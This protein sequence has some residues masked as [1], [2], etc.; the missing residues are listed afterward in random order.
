[1]HYICLHN[2]SKLTPPL[3]QIED[4]D[5]KLLSCPTNRKP[6]DHTSQIKPTCPIISTGNCKYAVH[7]RNFSCSCIQG[8]FVYDIGMSGLRDNC[9]TY[10]HPLSEHSDA[11][12]LSEVNSNSLLMCHIL[13]YYIP[14][15]IYLMRSKREDIT[16]R[17][18]M[19]PR[20]K[21]Q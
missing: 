14:P 6:L 3:T 17:Y 12:S 11:Q 4:Q 5:H 2:S 7:D 8:I 16:T 18:K 19:L 20:G 15:L 9:N 13:N 21:H 1:M 10:G